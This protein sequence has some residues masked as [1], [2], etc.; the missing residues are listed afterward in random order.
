MVL[1]ACM[2]FPSL[3]PNLP[4]MSFLAD[5]F[6]GLVILA[7]A[8]LGA[9]R[10]E[11]EPVVDIP[12]V[13]QKD[14]SWPSFFIIA[15]AILLGNALTAESTGFSAFLSAVFTPIFKGLSPLCFTVLLVLVAIVLTNV[16]NSLVIGLLLEPVIV[17]FCTQSGANPLPMV[18]MLTLSVLLTA[19]ITPAAC[20]YAAVLYSNKEWIPTKYTFRYTVT[21]VLAETI[22]CLVIG[23]PL[24]NFLM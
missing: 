23:I 18:T 1:I 7:V 13:L 14:F 11:K 24:A 8:I 21:Y 15:A 19:A 12:E 16:C 4:G 22:I 9:L 17:T 5:N 20:P 10:V 2:L 3:V 6:N